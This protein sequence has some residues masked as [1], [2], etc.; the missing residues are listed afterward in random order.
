M[1]K[2]DKFTYLDSTVIA[3][4]QVENEIKARISKA[5]ASMNKQNKVWKTTDFFCRTKLKLGLYNSLVISILLYGSE[6]WPV[7]HTVAKK[8]DGFD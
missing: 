2:V 7:T 4:N 3:N 1:Q 5:A 8:L 6:T